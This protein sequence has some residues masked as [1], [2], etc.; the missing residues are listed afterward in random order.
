MISQS[1][2]GVC[3]ERRVESV[4]EESM[5]CR[6]FFCESC[7]VFSFYRVFFFFFSIFL[8]WGFMKLVFVK[9]KENRRGWGCLDAT[10]SDKYQQKLCPNAHFLMSCMNEG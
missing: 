10:D 5:I 7:Y 9:E 4:E 6:V 1:C 8:F 3:A 2:V